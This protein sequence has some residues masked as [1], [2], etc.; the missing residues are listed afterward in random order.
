MRFL[1]AIVILIYFFG[2]IHFN[3]QVE[4]ACTHGNCKHGWYSKYNESEKIEAIMWM[5]GCPSVAFV[6]Y[7]ILSSR[8]VSSFRDDDLHQMLESIS[9]FQAKEVFSSISTEEKI[10]IRKQLNKY[11]VAR[12]Q[13]RYA[14]LKLVEFEKQKKINELDSIESTIAENNAWFVGAKKGEVDVTP[15]SLKQ[16][17]KKAEELYSRKR[18][19]IDN[20]LVKADSTIKTVIAEIETEKGQES[21]FQR[22]DLER[23]LQPFHEKR[24][25]A[26]RQAIV[27][28]I[29]QMEKEF[30]FEDKY[31]AWSASEEDLDES[32]R[33][34]SDDSDSPQ[35]T[36][37]DWWHEYHKHD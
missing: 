30:D 22:R 2:C 8:S 32:K 24:E 20:L 28:Q 11:R 9:T 4:E 21:L 18:T 10:F 12:E 34:Y 35:D 15:E 1:L 29:R 17:R 14:H 7:S 19:I 36:L 27:R 13:N 16:H 26:H 33:D 6:I 23:L 5:F 3:S 25:Y 31:L 37:D